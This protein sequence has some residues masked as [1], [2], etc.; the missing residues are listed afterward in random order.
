MKVSKLVITGLKELEIIG[1]INDGV[2]FT[3]K[4]LKKVHRFYMLEDGTTMNFKDGEAPHEIYEPALVE[5]LIYYL[6]HV[7]EAEYNME[8]EVENVRGKFYHYNI[9]RSYYAKPE[10]LKNVNHNQA[11]LFLYGVILEAESYK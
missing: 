3:K 10:K 7:L 9:K 8:F 5:E 1:K 4:F 11:L 2:G 6:Q